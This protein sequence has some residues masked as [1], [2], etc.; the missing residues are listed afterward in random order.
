MNLCQWRQGQ[1]LPLQTLREKKAAMENISQDFTY[2]L[3]WMSTLEDHPT[4]YVYMAAAIGL[5][6]SEWWTV[7]IPL[8]EKFPQARFLADTYDLT[9]LD[10]FDGLFRY[11][12]FLDGAVLALY[13]ELSQLV[14]AYG[15]SKQFV[16]TVGPGFDAS[17]YWGFS[18]PYI[19]RDEGRYY[20]FT[21]EQT[22]KARPDGVFIAS[23]NEWGETT[24]IEPA[25][26]YGYLYLD[27]TAEYVSKLAQAHRK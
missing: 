5:T 6:P 17:R 9:Y 14:H 4:I 8:K 27:L 7:L 18:S 21:W 23:W 10:C 25:L 2:L 26:E 12:A 13:P 11:G 16:A 24:A 19:P 20:R 22:L 3:Q 1:W 15:E